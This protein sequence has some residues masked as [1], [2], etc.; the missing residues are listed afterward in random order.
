MCS[1]PLFYSL[2]NYDCVVMHNSNTIIKCA[3]DTIVIC[4]ITDNDETA[5]RSDNNYFMQ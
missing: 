4:L 3:D 2:F 5:Y 1:K